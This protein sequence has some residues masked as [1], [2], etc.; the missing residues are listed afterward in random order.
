MSSKSDRPQVIVAVCILVIGTALCGYWAS[1]TLALFGPVVDRRAGTGGIG[2]VS[3]GVLGPE[4]LLLLSPVFTF[5]LTKKR[6]TGRLGMWIRRLHV[7]VT[8]LFVGVVLIA[9]NR[10][11]LFFLLVVASVFFPV[12]ALFLVAALALRVSRAGAGTAVAS[13]DGGP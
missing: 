2:A 6:T 5:L 4:P 1:T 3:V 7:C 9:A 11:D 10:G 8:A 13:R 12:Q